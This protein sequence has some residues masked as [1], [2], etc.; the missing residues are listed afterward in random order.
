[1][2]THQIDFIVRDRYIITELMTRNNIKFMRAKHEMLDSALYVASDNPQLPRIQSI[3]GYKPTFVSKDYNQTETSIQPA[4][5]QT[6]YYSQKSHGNESYSRHSNQENI[7]TEDPGY[8]AHSAIFASGRVLAGDMY[9][10]KIT[11]FYSF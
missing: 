11:L 10:G 7:N 1:M 2:A 4:H 9:D 5:Q 8:Y 6:Q 3:A